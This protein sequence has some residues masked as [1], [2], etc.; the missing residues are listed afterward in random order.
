MYTILNPITTTHIL[1][2]KV[3]TSENFLFFLTATKNLKRKEFLHKE[4][5]FDDDDSERM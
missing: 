3:V 1:T 4:K 2:P 5:K